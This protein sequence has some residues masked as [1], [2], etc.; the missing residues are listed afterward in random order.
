MY[1]LEVL[2]VSRREEVLVMPRVESL[3]DDLGVTLEEHIVQK[4]TW[5]LA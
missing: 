3:T 4:S 2:D 5:K 1:L